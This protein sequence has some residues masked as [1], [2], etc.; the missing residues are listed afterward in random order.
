MEP[1]PAAAQLRGSLTQYFTTTYALA[2]DDTR[3]ALERFL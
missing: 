2:D 3:R 1:T